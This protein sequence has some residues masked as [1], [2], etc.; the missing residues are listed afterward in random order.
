[1]TRSRFVTYASVL[2]L[3]GVGLTVLMAAKAAGQRTADPT[4]P[5][6]PS[7]RLVCLGYVDTKDK[8]VALYPENFPQPARVIKVLVHEGDGVKEG[9]PLLDF[10]VEMLSLRVREAENA[11]ELAKAEK[12]KAEA[13]VRAHKVQ[14]DSLKEE[15]EAKQEELLNKENELR[16]GERLF[17]IQSWNQLQLD[18]AKAAF[19]AAK[20]SLKAAQ[21]KW[22]GLRTDPPTY[23]IELAQKNIEK[24]QNAKAQAEHAR[25]QV[26]C[27]APA[28]GRVI[29]SFV[30]EGSTFGPT[31]RDPAFWFV[32]TGAPIV[33]A[34]VTQEF[35]RRV[36]LGR[37]ADIEDESDPDQHWTGKVVEV[38]DQFL[39]KRLGTAG[40][41][42]IMP[43]SDDR[44]LEC[45]VSVDPE[46][47][48][49]APRFG[50]KVRVTLR[51]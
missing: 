49:A 31:T 17:N 36:A 50:Q 5:A 15:L 3:S 35:A 14:V 7:K 42:D 22:E 26:R 33:R 51:N 40:L 19:N 32:K 47:G 44:V 11:I 21:Y 20:H 45:Q 16:E 25:D 38:P 29:R 12:Q 48:R 43:V 13:L 23:A 8:M 18:A 37:V 28:D 30:A 6:G 9:Q 39:P 46:P 41:L 27:R 4:K 1:M 24:A 34:E 2:A 10:D